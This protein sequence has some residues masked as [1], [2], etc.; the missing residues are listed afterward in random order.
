M[1][2][3]KGELTADYPAAMAFDRNG[4]KRYVVYNYGTTEKSV[5]Y[6]DGTIVQAQPGA[7]EIVV[8]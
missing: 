7:F 4:V 6:S 8:K 3:G 1:A 2:M 5:Q